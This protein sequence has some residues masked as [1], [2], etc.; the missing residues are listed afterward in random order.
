MQAC[1]HKIGAGRLTICIVNVVPFGDLY[2]TITSQ[3]LTP[4]CWCR[5][6]FTNYHPRDF[7]YVI[8]QNLM[9]NS[10]CIKFNAF[11]TNCQ[12][13]PEFLIYCAAYKLLCSRRPAFMSRTTRTT[14]ISLIIV[15]SPL[16]ILK[17]S[18]LHKKKSPL[19]VY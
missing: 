14:L 19:L 9:V 16:L 15:K 3:R 12:S 2:C 10:L 7:F 6:I 18:T 1:L 13:G 11:L 8:F 5:K 4:F 17:N